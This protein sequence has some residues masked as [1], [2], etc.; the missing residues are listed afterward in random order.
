MPAI[1]L[2]PMSL[3]EVLDKTFTLYRENFLLFAGIAAIPQL[4]LLIFKFGYLI[5]VTTHVLNPAKPTDAFPGGAAIGGIVAGALIGGIAA[6]I[7]FALTHA[8]TVSAVSEIYLG[9]A[10][11]VRDSYSRAKP[12]IATVIAIS[13]MVGLACLVGFLFFIIPG[14]YLAC[15]LYLAVPA[16]VVEQQSATGSMERSMTLTKD[17]AWQIFLLLALVFFL[18][19]AVTALFTFPTIFF[20]IA[21]AMQKHQPSTAVQIYSYISEFLAGVIVGPVGTIAASLM[22]YNLRVRKEGF[23]IQHLLSTIPSSPTIQPS[24]SL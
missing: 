20:T 5:T 4:L 21:A 6:L 7:I 15:R 16:A 17:Y 1:D 14:I 19:Y 23:D 12:Y 24:P 3:G 13:I 2:R 10:T 8:A 18:A 22:Y 11:T 9:R